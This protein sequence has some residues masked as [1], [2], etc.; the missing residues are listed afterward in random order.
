MSAKGHLIRD[1]KRTFPPI[2]IMSAIKTALKAAKGAL[3]AHQYD[4]A[5]KHAT[6]VLKEDS[7]N[8]HA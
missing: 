5:V 4:E 7:R 8:Y 2:T 1:L 3:D 6:E